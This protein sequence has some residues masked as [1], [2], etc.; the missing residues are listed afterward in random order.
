SGYIKGRKFRPSNWSERV[1]E[2]G[3]VYHSDTR[4]LEYVSYLRPVYHDEFGHCIYVNFDT[5]VKQ[6]PGVYDYLIWFIE[7]NGLEVI[8]LKG[9]PNEHE[10]G[11]NQFEAA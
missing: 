2:S 4:V 5:L 1:A 3:G 9:G 6:Q 8:P 7:S 10:Q 11:L